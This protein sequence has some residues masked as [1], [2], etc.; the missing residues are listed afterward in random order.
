MCPGRTLVLS[1]NVKR[2]LTL[3]KPK[4]GREIML[5]WLMDEVR[6]AKVADIQRAAMLLAGAREIRK[7][8]RTKRTKSRKEQM[9]GWRKYA[10]DSM[11]W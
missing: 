6:Q 9:Q 11:L 5:A 4:S 2:G 3:N 1:F 8:S 10:D 7:G